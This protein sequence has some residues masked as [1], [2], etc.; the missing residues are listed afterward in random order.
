MISLI[1]TA[2]TSISE[3]TF[4]EMVVN[5]NPETLPQLCKSLD[6]EVLEG[7][8]RMIVPKKPDTD[9]VAQTACEEQLKKLTSF[10]SFLESW[11]PRITHTLYVFEQNKNTISDP[12][13]SNKVSLLKNNKTSSCVY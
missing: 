8:P 11:F 6:W 1:S 5:H 10:V 7:N 2:Y 4:S 12:R 3:T 13:Q 9:R